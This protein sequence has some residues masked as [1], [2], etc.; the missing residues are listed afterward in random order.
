MRRWR[1]SPDWQHDRLPHQRDQQ[2]IFGMTTGSTGPDKLFKDA[3]SCLSET[4]PPDFS[5]LVFHLSCLLA[6]M[7]RS[8]NARWADASNANVSF[9]PA[10]TLVDSDVELKRISQTK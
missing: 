3:G 9:Y 4:M 2:H 6:E 8:I 10:H 7:S 1:I 5:C